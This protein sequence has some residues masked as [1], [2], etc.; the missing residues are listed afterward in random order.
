M[1]FTPDEAITPQRRLW[2]MRNQPIRFIEIHSTRGGSHNEYEAT[3]GWMQSANNRSSD[4][5]WGGSCSY[6]IAEDGRIC[7]VLTDT[8]QPTYGAGYGGA[9]STYSIDE[10]GIAVEW[11]QSTIDTDFTEAQYQRGADLYASYCNTYGIL[12]TMLSIPRQT[13]VAPSGFVRH[14]RCENGAKLGKSDPGPQFREVYFIGLVN[15]RLNGQPQGGDDMT[16]AQ[17]AKLDL[18]IAALG[19]ASAYNDTLPD[20][21]NRVNA[22]QQNE[23]VKRLSGTTPA[24]SGTDVTISGTFT[25]KVD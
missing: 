18:I 6:I 21:I 24:S 11:C 2:T 1:T 20:W 9:G 7:R 13:G 12:A 25:G 15:E 17:E 14:D 4:G 3:K 23:I 19:I 10:Y 22:I 8:Q 5:T 16:P